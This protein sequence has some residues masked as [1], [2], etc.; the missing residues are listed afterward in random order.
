MTRSKRRKIEVVAPHSSLM[1]AHELAERSAEYEEAEDVTMADRESTNIEDE[2]T[3]SPKRSTDALEDGDDDE[4]LE[5]ARKRVRRERIKTETTTDVKDG[6]ETSKKAR[7]A[8]EKKGP[9]EVEDESMPIKTEPNKLDADVIAEAVEH[10]EE[11]VTEDEEEKPEV[12]A[13]AR[14]KVQST[15]ESHGKDP[16]P[17][18]KAG[19]PVP[20]AAL[21]TTFSLIELTTKRLV[22]SAHCSLFLRQVLRLT[23]QDLLPTVSP[24]DQQAGCGLRWN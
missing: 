19:D 12:A 15:L 9:I 8:R 2:S 5:P 11:D 14:E 7:Y 4:D 1:A 21:C 13:K 6:Q 10:D 16:Y 24:H 23:P 18:W 20:Y 22:I 17:D 3:E